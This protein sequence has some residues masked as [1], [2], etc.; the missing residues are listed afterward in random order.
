[1]KSAGG[2]PSPAVWIV[3][4][5]WGSHLQPIQKAKAVAWEHGFLALSEQDVR[6]K[7]HVPLSAEVLA[8]FASLEMPAR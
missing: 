5:A 1:M 4:F 6:G 7:D 8:W 3:I 2:A